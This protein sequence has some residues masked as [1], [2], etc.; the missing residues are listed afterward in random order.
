MKVEL[1]LF[2]NYSE[3]KYLSSYFDKKVQS[4]NE[5]YNQYSY[6]TTIFYSS[7]FREKLRK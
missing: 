7:P 6:K 4:K 3:C 1:K 5:N 2:K